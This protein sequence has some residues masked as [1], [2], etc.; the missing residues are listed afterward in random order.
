MTEG[1]SEQQISELFDQLID[2]RADLQHHQ[3]EWEDYRKTHG[4]PLPPASFENLKSLTDYNERKALRE[5]EA[6][7]LQERATTASRQHESVY[8]RVKAVLP[9]DRSITHTYG[10][11]NA[12]RQGRYRITNTTTGGPKAERLDSDER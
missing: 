6:R 4:S 2:A 8:E 1:Y 7:D 3:R 11:E 10:G 12:E 9:R 5:R